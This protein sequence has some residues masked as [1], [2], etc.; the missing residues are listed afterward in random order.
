MKNLVDELH[1]L[2]EVEF[3]VSED[4]SKNVMKRIRKEETTS[5]I[6]KVIPWASFG[7]AACL[8]LVIVTNSNVKLNLFDGAKESADNSINQASV[9]ENETENVEDNKMPTYSYLDNSKEIFTSETDGASNAVND[10]VSKENFTQSTFEEIKKGDL[11]SDSV[12]L[13]SVTTGAANRV[14]LNKEKLSDMKLL[15]EKA[16]LEVEEIEEGLKVKASKDKVKDVLLEYTDI[17]IETQKEYVI[18]K[19]K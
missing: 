8:A 7:I 5:K 18:V 4:F 12:L 11:S 19:C 3:K 13:E 9:Y 1:K 16:N 15:I 10:S 17:S 6:T 14:K 2:D